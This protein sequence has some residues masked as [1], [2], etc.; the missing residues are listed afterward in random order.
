MKKLIAILMI[1]VLAC[2]AL[3]A[4]AAENEK[5]EW[6]D[7]HCEEMQF[8]TKIPSGATARY[9]ENQGLRIYMV[10]DGVVP[11]V[12]VTRR[13]AEYKFTNP[14]GYLNNVYR[15]YLE[16]KY[17]NDS[18]GMNPAKVM[19]IGGRELLGARYYY[20]IS[21]VKVTQLLLIDI[22]DGGD[23]EFTAKFYEGNEEVTMAALEEAVRNYLEDDAGA[24][25]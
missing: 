9:T 2:T 17:Q 3:S 1:L 25:K 12:Q 8:T 15:E 18:L 21:G 5:E 4:A 13:P 11:Y 23:V 24:A 7:F 19:E 22:R 6:T 16:N 20:R 10:D 14:S